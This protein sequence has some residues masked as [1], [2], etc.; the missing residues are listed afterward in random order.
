LLLVFRYLFPAGTRV[1]KYE[2]LAF[3]SPPQISKYTL[4]INIWTT[5]HAIFATCM[6]ATYF[7]SS[8]ASIYA[9]MAC[10]GVAWAVTTW[11]PFTLISMDVSATESPVT[12]SERENG[13]GIMIGLLNVAIC[14]PQILAAFVSGF[15]FWWLGNE[16]SGT[17]IVCLLSFGGVAAA[18]AACLCA[19]LQFP[20][21]HE[22]TVY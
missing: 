22:L 12:V 6:F 4:I 17:N 9:M 14:L 16:N 3:K 7:L 21:D 10:A 18:L 1:N 20:A 8:A 5:S 13:A 2:M 15:V 11:A 19:G